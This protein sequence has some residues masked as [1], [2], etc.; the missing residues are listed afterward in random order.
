MKV[1][2]HIANQKLRKMLADV[3]KTLGF[4]LKLDGIVCHL[5]G[6]IAIDV[7]DLDDRL[8]PPDG[9]S[10]SDFIMREYGEEIHEK[11]IQLINGKLKSEFETDTDN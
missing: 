2:K 7:I 3:N 1:D 10:L 5:T 6:R 9:T 11:I 8:Q 4:N